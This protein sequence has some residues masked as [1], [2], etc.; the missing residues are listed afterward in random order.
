MAGD[1]IAALRGI[2]LSPGLFIFIF[3]P[4]LLFEAALVIDV[5]RLIDDLAPILLLAV[6]AVIVTT[7][8]RRIHAGAGQRRRA[9]RLP[10][11]GFDRRHHG[12]GGGRRHL[13]RYR[14][15]AAAVGAGRRRKPVQRRRRPRPVRAAGGHADRRARGRHSRHQH[16]V[17]EE[18]HRRRGAGLCHGARGLRAGRAAARPAL[19]RDHADRL[20]GLFRVRG[21]RALSA[22]L[23]RR[24]G[25]DGGTGHGRLWPGPRDADHLGSPGGNLGAAWLLGQFADLHSRRHAGAAP[26]G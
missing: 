25:G 16:G 21:R 1:F 15:A 24:G 23:R 12:S 3:L 20:A 9:D 17:P 10:A 6:V 8:V 7:A 13:P 26:A 11:A 19:R 4:T 22:C 5:R 2:K 14:R 18:F